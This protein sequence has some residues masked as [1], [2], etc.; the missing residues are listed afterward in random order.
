MSWSGLMVWS[1]RYERQFV[2]L[3][4]DDDG[5]RRCLSDQHAQQWHRWITTAQNGHDLGSDHHWVLF[6]SKLDYRGEMSKDGLFRT[7]LQVLYLT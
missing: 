6:D 5:A 4:I 2:C 1:F 3:G 7:N